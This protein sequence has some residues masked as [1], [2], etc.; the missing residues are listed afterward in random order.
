MQNT[1][2]KEVN[3]KIKEWMSKSDLQD[4]KALKALLPYNPVTFYRYLNGNGKSI[5]ISAHFLRIIQGMP[6]KE[7]VLNN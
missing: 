2:L 4:R 6:I 7:T 5:H 3:I 1:E